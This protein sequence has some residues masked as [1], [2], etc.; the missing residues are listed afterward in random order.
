M[1]IQVNL[2]VKL[3]GSTT[4]SPELSLLNFLPFTYYHIHGRQLG[5]HI[6]F[7]HG[8]FGGHILFLQLG[9]FGLDH[10]NMPTNDMHIL[11][12]SI[13]ICIYVKKAHE[14]RLLLLISKFAYSTLLMRSLYFF[15]SCTSL[16]LHRSSC[17]LLYV[18]YL[19]QM[20]HLLNRLYYKCKPLSLGIATFLKG[21]W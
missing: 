3:G 15:V 17:S 13:D 18:L 1:T 10:F 2:L 14:C 12:L 4:G 7:H 11:Q 8:L 19:A 20:S 21:N 5:F 9:C 16:S 6:F